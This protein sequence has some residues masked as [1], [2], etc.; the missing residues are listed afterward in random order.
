VECDLNHK[1]E[2]SQRNDVFGL[3]TVFFFFQSGVTS[4]LETVAEASENSVQ[5]S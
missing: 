5:H 4:A 2:C 3:F 1:L